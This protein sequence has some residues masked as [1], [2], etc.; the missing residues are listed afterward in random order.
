VNRLAAAACSEILQR[1]PFPQSPIALLGLSPQ[2]EERGTGILMNSTTEILEQRLHPGSSPNSAPVL[3]NHPTQSAT[4]IDGWRSIL[5]GIP[6]FAAGVGIG[7][8]ALGFVSTRKH[9]PGWVI[10]II[11]AMFFFGGLFF[12]I[13]GLLGA[14]RKARYLRDSAERPGQPWFSDF[15][16]RQEGIAFSAFNAMLGR[17]LAALG[18]N[19]FLMPFF[20]IGFTVREARVFLVFSVIFALFGLFFWYRWAQMLADLLRYGN[21]FLTYDSFPYFLGGTLR[22]RLRP[23]HH[24][25]DIDALTLTLRCV[26]EKYVTSGSG[27]NRST[28]VVC[29][30]LYKDTVTLT[31]D[32][33]AGL[34]GGEIP[35]EFRLPADQS[36]TSLASTPPVYWEIEACGQ[37]RKVGYQAYFLVP[38]YKAS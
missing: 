3:Q 16:W 32:R 5:F 24:L 35:I 2:A 29:Y 36:T 21:S 7:L 26:Q 23:P 30:E 4:A 38:V 27:S 15:H 19:A 6:F 31:R 34:A 1:L 11:G 12:L 18:W 17:L 37:S 9:A 14:L 13:H 22:A 25:S 33:L 10:G 20:W 8:A 28:S